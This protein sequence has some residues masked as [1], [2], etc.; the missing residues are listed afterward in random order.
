MGSCFLPKGS[1]AKSLLSQDKKHRSPAS[2]VPIDLPS[3]VTP[4]FSVDFKD[5]RGN[6]S[7]EIRED[8]TGCEISRL[9]EVV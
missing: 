4:D 1:F 9:L 8:K 3:N 6:K 2:E 5:L 7:S